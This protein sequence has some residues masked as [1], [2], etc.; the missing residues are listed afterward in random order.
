MIENCWLFLENVQSTNLFNASLS[1]PTVLITSTVHSPTVAEPEN[2]P[3]VG[4]G[5]VPSLPYP[6]S[7]PAAQAVGYELNKTI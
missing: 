7:C 3:F 2:M 6:G 1:S 5:N 4:D